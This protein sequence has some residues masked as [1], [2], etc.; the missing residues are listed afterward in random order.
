MPCE[1]Q[2]KVRAAACAIGEKASMRRGD[3]IVLVG[4]NSQLRPMSRVATVADNATS[5]AVPSADIPRFR[6]VNEEVVKLDIDLGYDYG[7]VLADVAT[8]EGE[9]A[10]SHSEYLVKALWASYA[11]PTSD[12]EVDSLVRGMPIGPALEASHRVLNWK[13]R[14]DAA[15]AGAS[16]EGNLTEKSVKLLDAEFEVV[17]LARAANLGVPRTWIDALLAKDPARKQALVV[18][19]TVAGTGAARTLEGGDVVLTAG[20]SPPPNETGEKNNVCVTFGDV[21]DAVSAL[22]SHTHA[23]RMT[24]CRSGE[25]LDVAVELS[26]ASCLGTSRLTHWAGCILQNAHRPVAE[27]GFAPTFTDPATGAETKLDVFIS[28]WFHGSPAHRYGVYALHWVAEVNDR[29][30]PSL[31][32]F[33][34]IV[35][36]VAD[37]EHVRLKLVSLQGRPKVLTV[38]LDTHYW[39]TWELRKREDGEWERVLL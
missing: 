25:I 24:V 28:R 5:A 26:D 31:D 16:D 14:N 2:K 11:T 15:S 6:A 3:T 29:P 33:I 34:E 23:L 27:L 10:K 35:K 9:S 22:A 38:K 19:S 7:G 8:S 21:E 39:P 32:A 1:A 37:G 30:T 4:L 12:G 17:T 36:H 13:K 18:A 20:P